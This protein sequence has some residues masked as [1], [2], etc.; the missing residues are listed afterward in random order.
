MAILRKNFVIVLAPTFVSPVI[1]CLKIICV[2]ASGT[3]QV[4]LD[5]L[6]LSLSFSEY[7]GQ[8]GEIQKCKNCH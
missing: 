2:H 8:S 1:S 4:L 7:L 6:L 3:I 5:L